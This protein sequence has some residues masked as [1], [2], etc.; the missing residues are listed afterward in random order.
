MKEKW[1]PLTK[2]SMPP[3]DTLV[4]TS[5]R[6]GNVCVCKLV[7]KCD[8][9]WYDSSDFWVCDYNDVDA[10]MPYDP[11]KPYSPDK[12]KK[13][14]VAYNAI[15][16]A[17]RAGDIESQEYWVTGGGIISCGS[18]HDADAID[19]LLRDMGFKD[20]NRCCNEKEGY[21]FVYPEGNWA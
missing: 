6:F 15:C 10:W 18:E 4:W 11:P 20:V 9:C 19:R 21:W 7:G 5:D 8:C 16:D 1:I 3:F 13:A 14:V 17:L 12:N 2:N